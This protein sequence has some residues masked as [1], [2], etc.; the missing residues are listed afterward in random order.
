[1]IPK[2]FIVEELQFL[3]I[4]P[5]A[6]QNLSKIIDEYNTQSFKEYKKKPF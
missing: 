6:P 5:S 1:M 2:N 3:P 4:E